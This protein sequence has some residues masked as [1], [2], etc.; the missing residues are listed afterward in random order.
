MDILGCHF[1]LRTVS[2]ASINYWLIR[3]FFSRKPRSIEWNISAQWTN[4][5]MSQPIDTNS[6]RT[7]HTTT[8]TQRLKQKYAIV[9]SRIFFSSLHEGWPSEALTTS[10]TPPSSSVQP[11]LRDNSRRKSQLLWTF[12]V[13]SSSPCSYEELYPVNSEPLNRYWRP[14]AVRWEGR[15]FR[16]GEQWWSGCPSE[17]WQRTA[18][19]KMSMS[20][21]CAAE[22]R[23]T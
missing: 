21:K 7:T 17:T 20:D 8:P 2:Q 5:I 4:H 10:R 13:W 18:Q 15:H 11:L 9:S 6:Q 16:G 19:E 22:R 14:H 23:W 1:R 12:S 3:L